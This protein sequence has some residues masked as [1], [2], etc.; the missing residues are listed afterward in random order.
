MGGGTVAKYD[1]VPT[2][3]EVSAEF[4]QKKKRIKD[5]KLKDTFFFCSCAFSSTVGE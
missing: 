3:V 4:S 5:E 1:A 2:A